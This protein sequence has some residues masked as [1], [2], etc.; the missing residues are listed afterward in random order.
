MSEQFP[1]REAYLTGIPNIDD[2]HRR[3]FDIV[4]QVFAV[5]D[6]ERL[7]QLVMELYRHTRNHFRDEE[8]FLKGVGFADLERH[9]RQHDA[10][11]DRLNRYAAGVAEDPRR[12][13]PLREFLASWIQEHILEHDR[14]V[15]L[16]RHAPPV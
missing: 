7:Q 15:E 1:W 13:V 8:A 9:R 6:P 5:Q 14:E 3:L 4:N 2:Q 16:H 11:L 10:L 12:V